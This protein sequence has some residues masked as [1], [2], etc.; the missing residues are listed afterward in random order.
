MGWIEFLRLLAQDENRATIE[1]NQEAIRTIARRT[2]V[3]SKLASYSIM[4]DIVQT[5]GFIALLLTIV[6][7][8]KRQSK[9]IKDLRQ[10]LNENQKN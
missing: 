3:L 2:D 9:A 10:K 8:Y 4:V 5:I 1:S 7:V 6:L